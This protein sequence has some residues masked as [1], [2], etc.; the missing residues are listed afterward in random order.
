MP[1]NKRQHYVPR[2]Y[3]KRFS[4]DGKS[5]NI[6]HLPGKEK[7]TSASLRDQ[8]Y[9]DYFY[10]KQLD[11]E[12]G[13]SINEEHTAY[14]LEVI[15]KRCV[16][17]PPLSPE[18][19]AII[20]YITMQHGRTKFAADQVN[21]MH[22]QV[23]KH[24]HRQPL[25]L[26]GI[27][28]DQFDITINDA[29]IFTL[30]MIVQCYPLLL[31]LAYKLLLNKTDVDFV[32]SDNPVVLY[33]QLFSFRKFGSNA[34]LAQKGLQIFLP[35]SPKI[36]LIFYDHDVY[37]VGKRH[38]LT[39]NLDIA[40]DVY[41]LNTLQMC[42][43]LNCVYFRDSELDVNSLY[44]KASPYFRKQKAILKVFTGHETRFEKE[45]LIGMSREDIRTN[46]TLSFLRL[47]KSARVWRKKFQQQRPQPV[48]ILRNQ[49]YYDVYEKFMSKVENG[50][51]EIGDF[52]QYLKG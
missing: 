52:I 41:E 47:T 10:S 2:F 22:D 3:L 49:E 24:L 25:K 33:N 21:D 38:G 36:T 42:S 15:E 7:I 37:T 9:K 11:V 30:G 18:H 23:F 6:W 4:P 29:P 51:L 46:L 26:K 5:I 17:P 1:Q 34:G 20:L 48:S 13:L 31:D 19:L 45:E 14:L 40:R 12:K 39:V 8:C 44:R 50:E 32:T 35:I 16:L 28:I 43:A 27:D